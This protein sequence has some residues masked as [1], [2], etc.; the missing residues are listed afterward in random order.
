MNHFFFVI[1]GLQKIGNHLQKNFM[2]RTR[3]NLIFPIVVGI[4]FVL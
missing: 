2:K 1:L 4:N 3:Q